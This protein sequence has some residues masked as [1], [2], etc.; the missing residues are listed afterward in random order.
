MSQGFEI[1]VVIFLSI[2]SASCNSG[3]KKDIAHLSYTS[4]GCFGTQRTRIDYYSDLSGMF[5]RVHFG[6]KRDSTIVISELQLKQL[7]KFVSG[8]RVLKE[9]DGCTLSIEYAVSIEG[10]SIRRTDNGCQEIGF[11]NLIKGLFKISD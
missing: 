7:R 4:H 8:L 9:Q 3:N 2:W 1:L 6:D 5:A 10:E 11:D